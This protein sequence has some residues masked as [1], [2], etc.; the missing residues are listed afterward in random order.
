MPAQEFSNCSE[1]EKAVDDLA[2]PAWARFLWV[3][4][5]EEEVVFRLA[6]GNDLFVHHQELDWVAWGMN[7]DWALYVAGLGIAALKK[8]IAEHLDTK[9]E[10]PMCGRKR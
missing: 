2:P 7:R 4:E 8:Q 1:L 6:L 5:A 9:P 10:C 3:F